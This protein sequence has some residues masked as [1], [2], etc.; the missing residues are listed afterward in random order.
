MTIISDA[1]LSCSYFF[2]KFIVPSDVATFPMPS[3]HD[4]C[5]VN[6]VAMS[7]A[8]IYVIYFVSLQ[9]VNSPYIYVGI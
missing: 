5:L 8:N 9:F 7:V 6:H 1:N 3:R 4:E 2:I